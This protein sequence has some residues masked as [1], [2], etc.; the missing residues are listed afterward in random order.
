LRARRA[1]SFLRRRSRLVRRVPDRLYPMA[2]LLKGRAA[3]TRHRRERHS[4][5]FP[6]PAYHQRRR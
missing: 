6:R 5:I 3:T 1:S 2:L 4:R